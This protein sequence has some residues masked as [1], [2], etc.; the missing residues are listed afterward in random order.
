MFISL[1]VKKGDIV[2]I[3]IFKKFFIVAF[4]ECAKK[5]TERNTG[6]IEMCNLKE[7][8]PLRM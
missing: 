4:F 3:C 7:V 2:M 8:F 5:A 6:E 1:Y